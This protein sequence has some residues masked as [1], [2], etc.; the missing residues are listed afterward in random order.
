MNN[1]IFTLS[2]CLI[3]L[4]GA[5][6]ADTSINKSTYNWNGVY[7]GGFVGGSSGAEI[8]NVVVASTVDAYATFLV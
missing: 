5:T 7:V 6:F 2:I 8:V 1:N 4:S 3:T